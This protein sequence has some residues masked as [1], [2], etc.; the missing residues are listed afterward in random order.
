MAGNDLQTSVNFLHIGF[1]SL[2]SMEPWPGIDSVQ[3]QRL[4]R[5]SSYCN[6]TLP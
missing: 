4:G 2:Q 5:E 3:S 6:R 1:N